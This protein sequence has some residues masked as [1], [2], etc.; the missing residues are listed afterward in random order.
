MAQGGLGQVNSMD[1]LLLRH[2]T[3]QACSRLRAVSSPYGFSSQF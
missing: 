3:A 1:L 2:G